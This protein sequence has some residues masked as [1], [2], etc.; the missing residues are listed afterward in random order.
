MT[1]DKEKKEAPRSSAER[2]VSDLFNLKVTDHAL[3]SKFRRALSPQQ[4]PAVWEYLVRYIDI[5]KEIPREIFTVIGASI[6]LDDAAANGKY[7]LG[8]ALRNCSEAPRD[9]EDSKSDP[10]AARLRRVIACTNTEELTQVIRPV[11]ALIRSK[12]PG[13]LDYV[14]LLNDLSAFDFY[15]DNIKARWVSEFYKNKK[16]GEEQ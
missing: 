16:E 4:A 5:Q 8:R 11:L 2:F 3:R 6:A 12:N 10:L 1:E 13:S 14:K 7:G 9:A 15:G